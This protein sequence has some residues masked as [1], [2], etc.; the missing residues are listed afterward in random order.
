M[1][2]IDLSGVGELQNLSGT[3]VYFRLVLF[4]NTGSGTFYFQDAG[5]GIDLSLNGSVSVIPAPGAMAL[6]GVAG[7]L[8]ARRRR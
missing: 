5:S 6:L 3:N 8:G 4:G 1:A 2:A 7:L